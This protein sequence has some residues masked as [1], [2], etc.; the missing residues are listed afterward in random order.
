M[1]QIFKRI[2]ALILVVI[3]TLSNVVFN[4]SISNAAVTPGIYTWTLNSSGTWNVNYEGKLQQSEWYWN[5]DVYKCDNNWSGVVKLKAGYEIKATSSSPFL[6]EYYV[7]WINNGTSWMRTNGVQRIMQTGVKYNFEATFQEP[8]NITKF[9]IIPLEPKADDTTVYNWGYN[10]YTSTVETGNSGIM[11][12]RPV[13]LVFAIDTSGSM[14]TYINSVETNIVNFST[15]LKSQGI[16]VRLGCILMGDHYYNLGTVNGKYSMTDQPDNIKNF[17]NDPEGPTD[18][19]D[20]EDSVLGATNAINK[21]NWRADATKYVVGITDENLLP[22]NTTQAIFD[23]LKQLLSDTQTKFIGLND[24]SAHTLLAEA[25]GGFALPLSAN[26]SDQLN[27]IINAILGKPIIISPENAGEPEEHKGEYFNQ[28]DI[29]GSLSFPGTGSI[30]VKYQIED[31]SGNIKLGPET[32]VSGLVS[33]KKEILFM[34]KGIDIANCGLIEYNHYI[35]RV[36]LEVDGVKLSTSETVEFVRADSLGPLINFE[37]PTGSDV[38]YQALIN[39]TINDSQSGVK[40]YRYKWLCNP[41][42]S[43]LGNT[44]SNLDLSPH[45]GEWMPVEGLRYTVTETLKFRESGPWYLFAQATDNKDIMSSKRMNKE[46]IIDTKAPKIPELIV[47]IDDNNVMQTSWTPFSEFAASE[48]N[49]T[50]YVA[51][52]F[53]EMRLYVQKWGLLGNTTNY[54]WSNIVN[55]SKGYIQI[56]DESQVSKEITSSMLTEPIDKVKLRYRVKIRQIDK[57]ALDY[58]T[59]YTIKDEWDPAYAVQKFK[60]TQLATGEIVNIESMGNIADSGWVHTFAN[61]GAVVLKYQTEPLEWDM[62]AGR[63]KILLSWNAVDGASGYQVEVYDGNQWSIYDISKATTWDSSEQK[64]YPLTSEAVLNSYTNDSISDQMYLHSKEGLDLRDNPNTI[65]KKTIGTAYNAETMYSIRVRPYTSIM[66]NGVEIQTPGP[67][68]PDSTVK[69]E[70]QNRT[71]RTPPT[72]AILVEYDTT[73]ANY[74]KS[75][76][77]TITANDT[78][79]GPQKIV[80][81]NMSGLEL[82]STEIKGQYITNVYKTSI[83]GTYMFTAFDNVGW[84]KTINVDVKNIDPAKPII[85]FSREGKLVTEIH[86]SDKVKSAGYTKYGDTH[87]SNSAP[88]ATNLL[89]VSNNVINIPLVIDT[90]DT[91]YTIPYYIKL[92]NNS[93]SAVL[94]AK[95]N[96]LI[97]GNRTEI[98]Q[99]YLVY[100]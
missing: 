42:S 70:L 40:E 48:V 2:G 27:K 28:M 12:M 9:A 89:S 29:I 66:T 25:S 24:Q 45:M 52:G 88:N 19:S 64:L 75:A 65:Y 23:N 90:I 16:D 62:I 32:L 78:E 98:I 69:V 91:T 76:F 46:V 85:V 55:D 94:N 61:L 77:I 97:N 4:F 86:L 50:N 59:T 8:T 82:I 41:P 3:F 60:D 43:L 92:Q 71:D 72:A 21:Y 30:T 47:K 33:N 49:Q 11:T 83:N 14:D 79:S 95:F 35:L 13:D 26:L 100:N 58:I 56:T 20:S 39:M 87:G 84:T 38:A 31:M 74:Y 99:E 54:G 93:G 68:G 44:I 1:D 67:I 34:K 53:G 7:L 18:N 51:S 80:P 6:D 17:L 10:L 36:Y 37:V 22:G 63:G 57:A 5:S 15:T 81:S 73:V 96:V